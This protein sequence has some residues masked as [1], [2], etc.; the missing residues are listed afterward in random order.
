M[1]LRSLNSVGRQ[2][3]PA[4]LWGKGT[5]HILAVRGVRGG[6]G[7]ALVVLQRQIAVRVAV[8]ICGQMATG[9]DDRICVEQEGKT[10][11]RSGGTVHVLLCFVE[12][13]RVVVKS[14]VC[15]AGI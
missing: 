1:W 9:L 6:V 5:L 3:F 4:F 10:R 7:A 2:V 12:E 14:D 8:V 13:R 15:L 11:R